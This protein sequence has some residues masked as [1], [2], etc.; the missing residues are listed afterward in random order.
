MKIDK[1]LLVKPTQKKINVI[2]KLVMA[3]LS[4]LITNQTI[5]INQKVPT[6]CF[7]DVIKTI[8]ET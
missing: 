4:I 5:K 8:I 6:E 2:D 3:N 7:Y 1:L